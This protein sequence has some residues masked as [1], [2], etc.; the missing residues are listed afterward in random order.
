MVTNIYIIIQMT[1]FSCKKQSATVKFLA[2]I[3]R[4]WHFAS[5]QPNTA[6]HMEQACCLHR[7]DAC[8][9]SPSTCG[10]GA[11]LQHS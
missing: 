1:T 5:K 11:W 4:K 10:R 6:L 3:R 7:Y 2:V 9:S 8:P